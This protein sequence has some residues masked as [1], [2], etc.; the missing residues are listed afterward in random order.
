MGRRSSRSVRP[1]TGWRVDQLLSGVHFDVDRV[2]DRDTENLRD[3]YARKLTE[4]GPAHPLVLKLEEQ[5][6]K[7]MREPLSN[8][9]PDRNLSALLDEFLEFRLGKLPAEERERTFARMWELLRQ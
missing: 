5:L 8:M 1:P 4:L 9:N 2:Y 7:Q 3:E 6:K